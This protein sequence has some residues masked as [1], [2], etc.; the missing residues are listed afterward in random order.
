MSRKRLYQI[1]SSLGI[2]SSVFLILV[3]LSGSFL[4]F[5]REIDQLLDPAEFKIESLGTRRSIDSLKAELRKQ[6]PSHILAGWLIPE[7]PDQPD[8]VWVHFSDSETK[9]ESVILLDP[10]RGEVKGKLKEDR[11]DSFYGWMLNLHYTLLLGNTG[12]VMIGFLGLIFFFQG[13]SGII[14]Y[15]NIWANLFRLRTLESIRTFFS[16]LHKLTGVFTLVFHLMLGFTGAWWSLSTTVNTLIDGFPSQQLGKFMDDSIS[17]DSM[18]EGAESKI[19][20]FKLGFISFPHHKEGDP[21]VLYG[22]ENEDHPLRSRF[23]SY[24][25]FDSRSSQLLKVWELR[26]ENFIH[27]ILDSFRP[28]HFGTFGGLFTKI[29]W[30]ILGLAPG[31]LSLTGIGILISKERMKSSRKKEKVIR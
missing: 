29:L 3:G 2:F 24:L 31:I 14:L 13:I 26:K 22:T 7:N 8:Q 20:G 30:V 23:G 17:I 16:D 1:H 12:Y 5:A 4:I 21:V 19:S 9:E 18:I 11:S 27:S 25:V 28:L 10:Y 15:R 6:I